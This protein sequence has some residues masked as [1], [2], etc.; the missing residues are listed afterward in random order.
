MFTRFLGI[1]TNSLT[2]TVRQPIYGTLLLAS[3][4]VLVLNLGLAGYTFDDDNK[5]LKDLSL[6][7][8][9]VCGLFLAAFSAAGVLSREIE[10]KTVLTV[11]SKPV[12]R[13]LFILGKFTGLA[14]ALAIAYYLNGIVFLL[15]MRHKVM[16]R[17]S[18]EFDV[19]VIVFGCSAFFLT[20]LIAALCNYL[21]DMQFSSTSVTISIPLMTVA[22]ILVCL[23]SPKWEIQQFGKDFID[24]QIIGAVALVFAMV[25]I[26]TAVAVAVS[27]RLGQVAT[28][29]ICTLVLMI[30]LASDYL[31]GQLRDTSLLGRFAY[32]LSP[33]LAFLW[34]ADALTQNNRITATYVGMA[35]GYAMLI[36]LAWLLIAVALFQ[37]REVG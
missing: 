10:N 5:L 19:P 20:M 22:L 4:F 2:E 24:G 18:D 6:S 28:L 14:G 3:T 33:N 35:F 25:M 27:T 23:I 11:V 8:M 16:S 26:A 29:A 7:T 32:W 1:A 31:F 15:T 9:L 12:G 37:K 30:G 13:P 36:V 34:V 21:Y 17:S